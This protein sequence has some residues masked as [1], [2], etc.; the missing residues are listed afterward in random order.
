MQMQAATEAV[1]TAVDCLE[2][3]D[4]IPV[5]VGYEIDGKVTR[6]FPVTPLLKRA[7]PV[8]KVMPGFKGKKVRGITSFDELP[9]EVKDYVLFIEKE[10]EVPITMVST[11]PRR[12]ETIYR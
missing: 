5:C 7:K 4:E 12:E 10:I 2:Y 1:L 9:Q 11:G 8:L 6:D 3:L